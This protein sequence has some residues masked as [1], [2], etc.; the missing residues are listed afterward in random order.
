[1]SASGKSLA[2][3]AKRQFAKDYPS[4]SVGIDARNGWLTVDGKKAVNMSQASGSPMDLEDVIDKMKK[5]YLGHPIVEAEKSTVKYN[6]NPALK[7]KQTTL[8][9][10][11][12]KS[13]IDKEEE[14][15]ANESVTKITKSQL[16]KVVREGIAILLEYEQYV[17]EDGWLH[18]DEGNK[19]FV[20][21]DVTPGTYGLHD[22]PLSRGSSRSKYRSPQ[23]KTS[24]VGED[25]NAQKIAAVEKLS[26][27]PGTFLGSILQQLKKGR[28]LSAK[29]KA[30][31]KKIMV[32]R[33]SQSAGL[34]K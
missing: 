24:Y 7:G 31:V 29:Q 13:I 12:Q 17:D 28:G 8:P 2:Q 22:S 25:A 33:D 30:I 11:L 3:R 18:D 26:P 5:A 9:D 4:I 14:E 15:S 34:F 32:K 20:G 16:R 1:M 21:K 19:K 23:R 10:D 6:A 27:K